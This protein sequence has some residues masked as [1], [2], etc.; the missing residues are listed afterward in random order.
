MIVAGHSS[1]VADLY[2]A[3]DV[4]V[5]PAR[6]NEPFGRVP[7]EA[8]IAGKPAVV[9]RVG[10][11]PE[12][13]RDGESALIVEPDDPAGARGGRRSRALRS[14]ARLDP[15]RRARARSSPPG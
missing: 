4:I 12:L 6:F 3:A 15:G 7:F 2:A 14:G 9:T 13:L 1:D 11:I 5:N 10:A 8:A